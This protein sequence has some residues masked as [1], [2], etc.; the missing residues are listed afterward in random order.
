MKAFPYLILIAFIMLSAITEEIY[1]TKEQEIKN[2]KA[3]IEII[4]SINGFLQN[5]RTPEPPEPVYPYTFPLYEGEFLKISSYFG[6]RDNPLQENIGGSDIKYHP[7]VDFVGIPGARIR[8]LYSGIVEDKWYEAGWH[9]G[10]W[11]NGNKDFNGYIRIRS[12]G[13]ITEVF[14]T[15]KEV[16]TYPSGV[17]DGNVVGYGHVFEILVHE[18]DFVKAGQDLCKIN[19]VTDKKS[20]GPHLHLSIQRD[21]KTFLNPLKFVEM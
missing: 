3:D 1:T 4:R 16:Y 7:A 18:G 5:F 10:E 11:Y 9:N 12:E 14:Y 20:T 13:T 2:R 8:S 15:G 6:K 21:D 19:P 17:Y